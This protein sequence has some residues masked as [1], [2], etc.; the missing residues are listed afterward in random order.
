MFRVSDIMYY[1]TSDHFS[2]TKL[3]HITHELEKIE[4]I[5]N[6]DGEKVLTKKGEFMLGMSCAALV[7]AFLYECY[8]LGVKDQGIIAASSLE[9]MK[10]LFKESVGFESS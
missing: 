9:N 5:A 10:S 4:A 2:Q 1:N 3:S 6:Y 8:K 7:G